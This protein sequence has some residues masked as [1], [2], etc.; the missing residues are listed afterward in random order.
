MTIERLRLKSVVRA[1][2]GATALFAAFSA[3]IAPP[4]EEIVIPSDSLQPY[5]AEWR[6]RTVSGNLTVYCKGGAEHVDY[7][8]N[9]GEGQRVSFDSRGLITPPTATGATITFRTE[10]CTYNWVNGIKIKAHEGPIVFRSVGDSGY[11]HA[12]GAGMCTLPD[13]TEI[14]LD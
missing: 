10:D 4:E 12:S 9:F 11:A 6:D 8:V 13:G 3:C 2:L 14:K 5:W 7:G 1:A